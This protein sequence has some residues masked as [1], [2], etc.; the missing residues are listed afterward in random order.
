MPLPHPWHEVPIGDDAPDELNVVVEISSGSKVKYELDKET[1]LLKIDRI[2]YSSV[3]YPENYGFLP[4]TLA[5]DDDPLDVIIL[6]QAPIQPLSVMEARPIGMLHMLDEGERDENIICV[7]VEDPI[8]N[9]YNHVDEF[10]QHRWDELKQFFAE[11]K[12]LEGKEVEVGD[13][14]GPEEAKEYIQ[15]AMELYKQNVAAAS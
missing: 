8:Y 5:D 14:V 15:H 7:N 2:L 3:V 13:I 1:G 4:Q 6:T 10:P 11:Y 12:N 9:S